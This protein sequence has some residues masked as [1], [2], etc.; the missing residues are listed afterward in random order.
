LLDAA[1]PRSTHSIAAVFFCFSRSLR[2]AAKLMTR[3]KSVAQ[4]SLSL[5]DELWRLR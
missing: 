1:S 3:P 5:E 4:L 2:C